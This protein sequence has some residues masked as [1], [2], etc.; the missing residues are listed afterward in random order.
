MLGPEEEEGESIA[1]D[2]SLSE[3]CGMSGT[4]CGSKAGGVA[5]EA[6]GGGGGAGCT[7]CSGIAK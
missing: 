2:G 1:S 4:T 6:A 3:L 7:T 5:A